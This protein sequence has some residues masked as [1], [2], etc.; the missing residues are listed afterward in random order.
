MAGWACIL[1]AG[2][3]L[4][5]SC[6]DEPQPLESVARYPLW[7]A[8]VEPSDGSD[9]DELA[10]IPVGRLVD[11][12]WDQPWPG[13]DAVDEGSFAAIDSSG[14]LEVDSSRFPSF[15]VLDS[16]HI[17]IGAPVQW[18][19]YPMVRDTL[20]VTGIGLQPSL[21]QSTLAMMVRSDHVFDHQNYRAIRE[22]ALSVPLEI[23]S[24]QAEIARLDSIESAL[25]LI[26]NLVDNNSRRSFDWL[27]F[28]RLEDGG[29]LGNVDDWGY[30]GHV[31]KIVVFQ[32]DQAQ[33]VIEVYGGGC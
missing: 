26:N 19:M 25:G 23:V 27:G 13:T 12:A 5:A 30:E 4:I 1:A 7:V 18:F 14:G 15:E 31:Y 6:A 10:L 17:R 20:T 33:V 22:V 2:L 3:I 21:C 29:I 9:P 8:I 28:H 32:G 24:P 16:G 11:G